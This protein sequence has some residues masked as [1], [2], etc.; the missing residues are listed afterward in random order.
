MIF[1]PASKKSIQEVLSWNQARRTFT[2]TS[3]VVCKIQSRRTQV[4]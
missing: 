2:I 1:S 3:H 4:D